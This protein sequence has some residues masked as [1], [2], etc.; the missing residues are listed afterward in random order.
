MSI[1][2]EIKE[3]RKTIGF[4]KKQE[5]EAA[6]MDVTSLLD[7][8]PIRDGELYDGPCACKECLSQGDAQ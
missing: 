2:N 1:T 3:A 8:H 5:I 7:E 6:V 4:A